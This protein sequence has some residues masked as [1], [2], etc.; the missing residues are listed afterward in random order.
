MDKTITQEFIMDQLKDESEVFLPLTATFDTEEIKGLNYDGSFQQ[1]EAVRDLVTNN[2]GYSP[3]FNYGIL[4]ENDQLV[5]KV[6][7]TRGIKST[8]VFLGDKEIMKFNN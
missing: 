3:D 5:L 1:Y 2:L 6:R 4:I 8:T 7:R